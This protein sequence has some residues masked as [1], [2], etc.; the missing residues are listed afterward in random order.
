MVNRLEWMRKQTSDMEKMLR[1]ENTGSDA[2]PDLLRSIHDMDLRMQSVEYKLISKVEANSDDKYYVEPYK[3]Y[4][5][6]IWLNGE[7]GPG[8]GDVAG[9]TN[10][11]PTD[12]SVQI[13]DMLEK[14][15]AAARADYTALLEKDLPA[16]NRALAGSGVMPVS[17]GVTANKT[18]AP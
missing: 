14:E 4:L 18:G 3:I 13:L 8:A 11:G 16:F 7:V 5:N 10:Y 6:L 2:K 12:T 1:A 9:G 15:L 17:A